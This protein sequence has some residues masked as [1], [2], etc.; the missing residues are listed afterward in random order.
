[1]NENEHDDVIAVLTRDHRHVQ[2]LFDEMDETRNSAGPKQR[3]A[4]TDRVTTELARHS[5]AEEQFLY[6]VVRTTVVGGGEL[7]DREIREHAQL[8]QS[9][10]ELESMPAGDT[11]FEPA[12][13]HLNELVEAHIAEQEQILFPRLQAVCSAEDLVEIGEIVVADQKAAPARPMPG[14]PSTADVFGDPETHS[15]GLVGR[16]RDAFNAHGHRS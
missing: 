14:V 13:Q 16:I 15:P 2:A 5:T 8:E 6:P 11:S 7:A 12:L 9:L 1:V 10:K 4:Q 3:K